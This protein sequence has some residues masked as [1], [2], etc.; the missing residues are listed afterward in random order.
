MG[1]TASALREQGIWCFVPRVAV[2]TEGVKSMVDVA[3]AAVVIKAVKR[4]V[5]LLPYKWIF[6]VSAAL[7]TVKALKQANSQCTRQSTRKAACS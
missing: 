6:V 2:L 5:R 3:G 1:V 4:T 7:S